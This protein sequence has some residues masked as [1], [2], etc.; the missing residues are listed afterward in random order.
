MILNRN[1][2]KYIEHEITDYQ[3]T[4]REYERLKDEILYGQSSDDENI[5]GGKGNL[6]T[7]QVENRVIKRMQSKQIQR[8][9]RV[10]SAI[11]SVYMSLDSYKQDFWRMCF[12][13]RKYTISG[14]ASKFNI[15]R[16]TAFRWKNQIVILVAK[17]LGF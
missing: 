1:T 17:E 11:E 8:L 7:S 5:G 3:R 14:L 2:K 16:R 12:W 15:S 10:I 6:P 9:E 13:E 4:K